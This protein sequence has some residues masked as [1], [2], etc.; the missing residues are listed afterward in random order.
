MENQNAKQ[1]KPVYKI[2]ETD[3]LLYLMDIYLTEW[4]HRDS[5]LWKQMYTFFFAGVV[6]NILPFTSIWNID[7]TGII[8]KWIF[9]SVGILIS[10]FFIII[11]GAYT[12]RVTTVGKTYKNLIK[13]LPHDLQ[14]IDI[15]D[16]GDKRIYKI[17]NYP[18]AKILPEVMMVTLMALSVIMLV[19]CI[20]M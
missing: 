10:I 19:I 3:E 5:W 12:I 11:S 20:N 1:E 4:R 7:F 2:K 9:P 17:L 8:P 18:M 13:M 14:R 16:L 15:T 6:V